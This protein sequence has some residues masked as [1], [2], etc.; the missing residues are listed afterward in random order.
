M[1]RFSRFLASV[2]AVLAINTA[3]ATLLKVDSVEAQTNE[4]L[5]IK[6]VTVSG[7]GCPQGTA[8]GVLSGDTLSVT[9]SDFR[10]VA[11]K[12]RLD[13]KSCNLRI[14][15]QVPSGYNLQ[16]ILVQYLGFADIPRGGAGSLRS[17]ATLGAGRI[18]S[19]IL[20]FSSGFSNNFSYYFPLVAESINGCRAPKVTTLGLNTSLTARATNIPDNQLTQVVLDTVDIQTQSP[21]LQIKF[22]YLPC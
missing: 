16:P 7:S 9:F 6:G 12:P 4:G 14:A 20:S 8:E 21:V 2:L 5:Q 17:I 15:I 3:P 22:R 1:N 11:S 13:N 10:A 18:G 19:G